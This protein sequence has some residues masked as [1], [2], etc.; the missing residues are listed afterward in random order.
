M[1]REKKILLFDCHRL[2]NCKPCVPVKLVRIESN[3]SRQ[4]K[5]LGEPYEEGSSPHIRLLYAKDKEDMC[6]A[7]WLQERTEKEHKNKRIRRQ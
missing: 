5:D 7:E 3:I 4:G 6:L 2:A 1:L